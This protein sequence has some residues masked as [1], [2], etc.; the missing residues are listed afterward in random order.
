MA[1]DSTATTMPRLR[2]L[3]NAERAAPGTALPSVPGGER[4]GLCAVVVPDD[5]AH[6]MD[7]RARTLLCVCRACAVL[8]DQR[9]AG[10]SHYRRV[11]DRCEPLGGR[12]LSDQQWAALG[13]PVA[14]AFFTRSTAAGGVVGHYPGPLG[15]TEAIVDAGSWRSIERGNPALAT[16]EPDVEALLADRR[17]ETPR[18]W[19]VSIDA[20]YALAGVMRRH[21][22]G[23][24]G[25]SDVQDA[26]TAFFAELDRRGRAQEGSIHGESIEHR[27]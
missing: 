26:V 3:A 15:V 17:G 7:L 27:T 22:K 16:L 25:G 1:V 14:V 20:C 19:L 13:V 10:G 6:M 2:R 12:G 8:F 24:A 18:Y 4:C 5:H 23:L 11:N 21:W 9:S